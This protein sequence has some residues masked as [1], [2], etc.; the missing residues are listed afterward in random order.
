LVTQWGNTFAN[1][2]NII[3]CKKK[4]EME[5]FLNILR[6]KM[7]LKEISEIYDIQKN[8]GKGQ[9]G[10]V[11]LGVNKKTGEKVAIKTINKSNLNI[12]EKELIRAEIDVMKFLQHGNHSSIAKLHDIFEDKNLIYIVMEYL[13]LGSLQNYL[14]KNGKSIPAY[15][16][17]H[18]SREIA[19]GLVYLEQVGI[20]HRDIKPDNILLS[21]KNGKL[22]VKIIDFGLSRVLGKSDHAKEGYGTLVYSAPEI[23]LKKPYTIKV[24]TW[25][26]GIVLYYLAFGILPFDGKNISVSDIAE[27]ICY[28]TL[29]FPD[30]NSVNYELKNLIIECLQKD[31]NNRISIT[32]VINS[33]YLN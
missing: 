16:L 7:N 26:Y 4:H 14:I 17:K 8:I 33:K 11:K 2:K 30:A 12:K 6:K 15:E 13:E 9:F 20:V 10:T 29:E 21:E 28:S 23:L 1:L 25:S 3:F 32:D 18:I 27:K 19:N 5:N 31:S 22:E 24:D